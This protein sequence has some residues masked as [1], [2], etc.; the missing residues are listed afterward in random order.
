MDQYDM[1]PRVEEFQQIPLSGLYE[2]HD[3]GNGAW[4][5]CLKFTDSHHL[6][7]CGKF[8][9]GSRNAARKALWFPG[10]CEFFVLADGQGYIVDADKREVLARTNC[11]C[12]EDAILIPHQGLVAVTNGLTIGLVGRPGDI[13]ESERITFDGVAFEAASED[14]VTGKLNDLTDDWCDFVLHVDEHRVEADWDYRKA[15]RRI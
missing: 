4:R 1:A 6:E 13:W 2:E 7:W 15:F 10:T 11:D 8:D 5:C 14:R 12:L 9:P 3:F